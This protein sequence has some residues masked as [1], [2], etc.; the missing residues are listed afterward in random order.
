MRTAE[1]RSDEGEEPNAKVERRRHIA[2]E[3]T[4]TAALPWEN[5]RGKIMKPA[6]PASCLGM[7][8]PEGL[9]SSAGGWS[10]CDVAC[11]PRRMAVDFLN[12]GRALSAWC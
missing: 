11:H 10:A 5:R 3:N 12:R 6:G 1:E 2:A 4:L 8:A 7:S 9:A